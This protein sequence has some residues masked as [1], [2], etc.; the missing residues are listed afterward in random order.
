MSD[1][2][3]KGVHDR[4]FCD[5]HGK[6]PQACLWKLSHGGPQQAQLR[7]WPMPFHAILQPPGQTSG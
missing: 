3:G 1:F 5:I 4:W 2:D 6:F 7:I